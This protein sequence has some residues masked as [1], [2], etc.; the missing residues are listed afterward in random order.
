MAGGRRADSDPVERPL[1]AE[2]AVSVAVI[3]WLPAVLSVTVNVYVP[4]SPDAN[5]KFDGSPA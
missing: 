5:V 3:D 2:V 4:S 1:M